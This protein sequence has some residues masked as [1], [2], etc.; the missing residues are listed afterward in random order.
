[1]AESTPYV[2]TAGGL[3]F[4]DRA[5]NRGTLDAP[6]A[7]ATFAAAL[8]TAAIDKAV[9][10]LGKGLA[11]IM[12]VAAGLTSGVAVVRWI[13][14]RTSTAGSAAKT[15]PTPGTAGKSGL[16]KSGSSG[17]GSGGGGGGSW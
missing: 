2:L 14:S 13:D 17:G 5:L 9:P 3:V 11:V 7:A 10:G 8:A 16:G 4:V 1:M 15:K 12:V 6:V